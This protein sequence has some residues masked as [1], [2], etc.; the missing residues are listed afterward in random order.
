MSAGIVPIGMPKLGMTMTE[1]RVVAWPRP[2]GAR[3]EKGEVVLVIESEKAEVE[4]EAPAAGWLRHVYVVPDRTVPCGTLLAVLTTTVDEPLDVEAVGR[5]HDH[6]ERTPPR[7]ARPLVGISPVAA[8]ER[9]VGGVTPAARAFAKEHGVE[10]TAVVGTGPQGRVTREDVEAYV[11]ARARLVAV[12]GGVSLEVFAQ[13]QGDPVVLI[14]GFGSDVSVFARQIQALAERHRVLAVNPRGVGASDG[15]DEPVYELAVVAREV[16]AVAGAPAHVVGASLGAAVA[17]EAALEQPDRVRSLTLITPFV[18]VNGRLLAVIDAWCQV[19]AEASP[20]ALAAMLLPL[21]F[22]VEQLADG[23]ARER[24]GRGLAGMVTR[25]PAASLLRYAAGLR[26]WS[27]RR[28]A[29]L[30]RVAVPT[31]VIAGADDLL[32]PDARDVAD[33][34][35]GARFVAIGGAAHAVALEV[36]EAVLGAILE[37]LGRGA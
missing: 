36:P 24:I 34:I 5:L 21:L 22:S 8:T 29:A 25:V 3:V 32:T 4:I 10:V 28:R 1:G 16:M 35:P 31:L 20:A 9:A 14:P 33:G 6:P 17:I 7:T 23:R 27:G 11:A 26:A 19:A 15:P 18:E 13:G 2:L 37:H 30:A 12:G